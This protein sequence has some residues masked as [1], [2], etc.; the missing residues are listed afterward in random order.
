MIQWRWQLRSKRSP[1]VKPTEGGYTGQR[2]QDA[3][4]LKAQENMQQPRKWNGSCS[5]SSKPKGI[6]FQV[7]PFLRYKY[8]PPLIFLSIPLSFSLVCSWPLSST[9]VWASQVPFVFSKICS[10]ETTLAKSPSKGQMCFT[11][12]LSFLLPGFLLIETRRAR[13]STKLLFWFSRLHSHT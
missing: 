10:G 12:T 6:C 3:K 2:K 9:G 7:I 13:T 8:A 1:A 4:R 11:R 5:V